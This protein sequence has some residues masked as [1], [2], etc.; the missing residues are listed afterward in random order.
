MTEATPLD[1]RGRFTVDPKWRKLLGRRIIQVWTPRGLLLR[2]ITGKLQPGT[3]PPSMEA[4]GDDEAL[5]Q[6]LERR[7][8]LG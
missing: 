7:K 8:R 3:F 2:P 1:D 4:S 5:R 6:A